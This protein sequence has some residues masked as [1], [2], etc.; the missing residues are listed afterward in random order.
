MVWTIQAYCTLADV[1]LA[2]DPSLGSADDTFISS[3]ILQAQADLDIEIGYAF[4]QDGTALAPATRLYDGLA[5]DMSNQ[6]I[7]SLWIDDLI[8]LYG[9]GGCTPT[10]CGAIF[11]TTTTTFLSS[12]GIWITGSIITNDI[13]ADVILKPNNFASYGIPANRMVRNSGL[14][15]QTGTQNYKVLGIFGRPI[16]PNQTYPGVPNDI[17]R[18]CIR[19]AV[20]YY[21]MRD[22]N[23]ADMM[24]EQ[25]GIRERYTKGW[26]DDVKRVVAKYQHHRFVTR[27]N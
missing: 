22:T 24:Q 11:E 14:S 15:F 21:K 17:M 25:G 3:L 12:G 8:S 1:K 10:P 6:A 7:Y 18:A 13:T 5:G 9:G 16:L 23:Y 2:L 20:H 19:L 4:Q 26:P 27:T